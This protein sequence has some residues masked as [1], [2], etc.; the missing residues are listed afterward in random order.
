MIHKLACGG[1]AGAVAQ[2]F[3]YPIDVIRRRMQVDPKSIVKTVQEIYNVHGMRGF[4]MGLLPNYLKVVPS[5]ST[6]FVVYEAM[7]KIFH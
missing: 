3:T 4:Y 2:T 7:I 5:I 6:S 1:V